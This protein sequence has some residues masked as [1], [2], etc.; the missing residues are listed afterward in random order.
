MM[1]S[2]VAPEGVKALLF[3]VFGT[4]YDW[5]GSIA[6]HAERLLK[7]LGYEADWHRLAEAWFKGYGA[8]VMDVRNGVASYE[9]LDV[10]LRRALQRLLPQFGLERLDEKVFDALAEAWHCLD[11]WPDVAP[12][13]ARLHADYILATCSNGSISMMVA[14]KRRNRL[15]WDTMLGAD[16]A[17][18]FKTEPSVY[19]KSADA[20][21][22]APRQVMFVAA[23]YYD[24]AAAGALGFRTAY[25]ARENEA[26]PG[27]FP[28]VDPVPVDVEARDFADFADKMR[29]SEPQNAK[30]LK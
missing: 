22:L 4:V 11:A 7:P 1:Q 23:H 30:D 12:G 8:A 2:G 26:P 19:L 9:K 16:I 3:D 14:L 20:L 15:P 21:G 10:F 5:R 28:P 13:F 27:L 18:T 6:R 17:Q 29:L 24:L 25:V